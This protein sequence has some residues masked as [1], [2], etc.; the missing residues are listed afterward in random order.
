MIIIA[1]PVNSLGLRFYAIVK[2][3]NGFFSPLPLS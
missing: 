2:Y 1:N 3:N